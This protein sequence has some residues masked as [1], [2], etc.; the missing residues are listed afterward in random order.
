METV[1]AIAA[2]VVAVLSA[3]IT[4]YRRTTWAGAGIRL[5]LHD[6]RAVD[7][8]IDRMCVVTAA[9]ANM[10]IVDNAAIIP[11]ARIISSSMRACALIFTASV[12]V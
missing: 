8:L 4:S 11:I 7:H 5:T 12:I 10:S 9:F 1:I 3:I 2:F 6:R